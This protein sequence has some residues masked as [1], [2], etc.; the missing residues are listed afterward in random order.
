MQIDYVHAKIPKEYDPEMLVPGFETFKKASD[1][2]TRLIEVLRNS[3]SSTDDLVRRLVA[4]HQEHRCES[5]A[6]PVCL[7]R[8]RKWWCSRVTEFMD[9]NEEVVWYSINIVDHRQ[10]YPLGELEKFE[11]QKMKERLRKQLERSTLS[12]ALVCGGIDVNLTYYEGRAPKWCPHLYLLTSSGAESRIRFALERHYQATDDTLRPLRIEAVKQTIKDRARVST[13]SF[14]ATFDKRDPVR[15]GGYYR[16]HYP[17][18]PDE[19]MPEL[20]RA[21]DTWGFG[22][23]LIRRGHSNFLPEMRVR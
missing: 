22:K 5:A 18:V 10:T 19:H 11:P 13:Y 7:R 23:R 8:F 17:P 3:S 21:L 4:C 16:K 15:G 20:A 12:N 6:C 1:R 9:R 2:R 14:K